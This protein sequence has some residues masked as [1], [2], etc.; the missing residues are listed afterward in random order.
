LEA[1]L[2]KYLAKLKRQKKKRKK[3]FL[4]TQ[5]LKVGWVLVTHTCYPSY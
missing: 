5:N 3:N 4:V 2:E 1:S